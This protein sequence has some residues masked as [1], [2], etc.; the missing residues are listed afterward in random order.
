MILYYIV[1]FPMIWFAVRLKIDIFHLF[2]SDHWFILFIC[3][4]FYLST[5]VYHSSL[6]FDRSSQK[7]LKFR[8]KKASFWLLSISFFLL[9]VISLR[10]ITWYLVTLAEKNNH[11]NQRMFVYLIFH[12]SA[13]RL[14][15]VHLY[16]CMAVSWGAISSL[17]SLIELRHKNKS[18]NTVLVSC[19]LH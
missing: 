17:F 8:P 11:V 3:K 10:S 2:C 15:L 12:T 16:T 18:S 19:W 7:S 1:C 9:Y 6:H 5:C 4:W 13:C 14:Y